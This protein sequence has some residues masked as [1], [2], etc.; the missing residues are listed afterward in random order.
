LNKKESNLFATKREN[1][2]AMAKHLDT[3]VAARLEDLRQRM[4]MDR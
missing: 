4:G 1:H 2:G 3:M